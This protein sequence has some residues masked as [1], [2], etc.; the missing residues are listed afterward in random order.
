MAPSQQRQ[1]VDYVSPL[2]RKTSTCTLFLLRGYP[3]TLAADP[4]T[5]TSI[6][7][8]AEVESPGDSEDN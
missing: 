2:G 1:S 7:L 8:R 6:T 4:Q 5:L 3:W